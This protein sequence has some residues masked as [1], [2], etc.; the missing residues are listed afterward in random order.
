MHVYVYLVSLLASDVAAAAK[1]GCLDL[2]PVSG[3][4]SVFALVS[5]S[6][7]LSGLCS[8]CELMARLC[9]VCEL[10]LNSPFTHLHAV[11]SMPLAA[12]LQLVLPLAG[13]PGLWRPQAELGV[14]SNVCVL[15]VLSLLCRHHTLVCDISCWRY[16]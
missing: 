15:I 6:K 9:S 16:C 7:L 12:W 1:Y 10:Q 4:C 11:V 14:A 8:V 5:G 3:L 13:P 2:R